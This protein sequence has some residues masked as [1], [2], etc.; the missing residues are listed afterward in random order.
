MARSFP[1]LTMAGVAAAVLLGGC[2]KMDKTPPKDLPSYVKL[3]PGAEP[4]ARMSLGP[5]SSELET[6]TDSPATV[7]AYYRTQAAADGLTE[8]QVQA[9]ASA[10]QGQMQTTF[11]D[12]TGDKMLIVLAKPQSGNNGTLVSLTYRPQKAPGS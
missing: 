10:A 4:T 1:M 7:I 8:K 6:T 9:P 5:M 2:L 3:Y 12:A 11:N